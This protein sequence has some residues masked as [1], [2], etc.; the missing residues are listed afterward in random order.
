M[1][2]PTKIQSHAQSIEGA[3]AT[4]KVNLSIKSI[5]KMFIFGPYLRNRALLEK[6]VK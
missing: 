5:E 6:S 2:L 3:V 4:G 1:L